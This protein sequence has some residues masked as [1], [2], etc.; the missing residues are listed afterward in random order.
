APGAEPGEEELIEHCRERLAGY[1]KP[2][3]VVFVDELPRNAAGKVLK[4]ELRD[5]YADAAAG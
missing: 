5:R 1:K 4:R 3:A 2:A